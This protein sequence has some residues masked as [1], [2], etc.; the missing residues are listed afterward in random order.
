MKSNP[1]GTIWE[2]PSSTIQVTNDMDKIE[3]PCLICRSIGRHFLAKRHKGSY[4]RCTCFPGASNSSPHLCE[5][6]V[7]GFRKRWLSRSKII[8]KNFRT[9]SQEPT[10]LILSTFLAH[11]RTPSAYTWQ[12]FQKS[13]PANR[14]LLD[15]LFIT[16]VK[17]IWSFAISHASLAQGTPHYNLPL[18]LFLSALPSPA[19]VL[20]WPL[21]LGKVQ[22]I[23]SVTCVSQSS[24]GWSVGPSALQVAAFIHLRNHLG[25][26]KNLSELNLAPWNIKPRHTSWN[27]TQNITSHL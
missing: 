23:S 14:D 18:L 4:H 10:Q 24:F 13:T 26:I 1:I 21:E 27:K 12:W 20:L 25:H 19:D 9:K 5:V 8:W 7:F 3:L 15:F 17:T 22:P 6:W 16:P 2:R 11:S